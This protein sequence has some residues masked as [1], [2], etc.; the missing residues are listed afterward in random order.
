MLDDD[1]LSGSLT[2]RSLCRA[3]SVKQY[4]IFV[5]SELYFQLTV[6]VLEE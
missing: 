6:D 5:T 2:Q 3:K 4:T 1:N